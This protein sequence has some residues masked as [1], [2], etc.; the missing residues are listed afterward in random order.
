MESASGES[1][2][3]KPT[4]K[5]LDKKLWNDYKSLK[6]SIAASGDAAGKYQ[7]SVEVL[8]SLNQNPYQYKFQMKPIKYIIRHCLKHM[9][10][11]HFLR[12]EGWL[13]WVPLKHYMVRKHNSYRGKKRA[14]FRRWKLYKGNYNRYGHRAGY[15]SFQRSSYRSRNYFYAKSYPRKSYTGRVYYKRF[16]RRRHY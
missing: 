4:Y 5:E 3:K 15:K 14:G 13:N 8:S 10:M 6:D 16:F 11:E 1:S 12:Q 7:K 9:P 2:A